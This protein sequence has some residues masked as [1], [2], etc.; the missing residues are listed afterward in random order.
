MST[1]IVQQQSFSF[2]A[3]KQHG[4]ELLHNQ[5]PFEQAF[6]LARQ[7]LNGNTTFTFFTSGST[8]VPK[9]IT[10][11]R[12][13]LEASANATIKALSLKPSEHI[14]VCMNTQFIGGAMLLIRGLILGATITLQEPSSNPFKHLAQHHPYTFAS[15]TPLQLF[16]LIQNLFGEQTILNQFKQV[17][18]GG[19]SISNELEEIL[20]MLSVKCYQTYGM[21]ETVSHIAIR[22]IGKKES[23]QLL[24]GV[25]YQTDTRGCIALKGEVTQNQWVQTNDVIEPIDS[26]HFNI[27]GRADDVINSGGIKV[28]PQK[29]EE[30][31]RTVLKSLSIPFS[32][33]CVAQKTDQQ[34]GEK[35]IVLI[36]TNLHE[37]D[38]ELVKA[39][40]YSTLHKYEIPKTAY[41][42]QQFVYTPSG[43]INKVET[44]KMSSL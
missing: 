25:A 29:V 2:D 40:L 11:N 3:I 35:V 18:I 30:Q 20:S 22:Q 21:T 5:Q 15:F 16:P 28:W 17:L 41:L 24:A 44:L 34:L 26:N 32:N 31:L 10:L 13:Q 12:T 39:K 7:W 9:A 1:I 27:L 4:R 42:L 43:K 23:Y 8:G 14:L 33:I 19:A 6:E 36:E 38:W 37:L